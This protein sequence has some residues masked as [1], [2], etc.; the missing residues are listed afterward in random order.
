MAQ[1]CVI[2]FLGAKIFDPVIAIRL[3]EM[4]VSSHVPTPAVIRLKD[5]IDGAE[6]RPQT[7]RAKRQFARCHLSRYSESVPVES[8]FD[9]F[10]GS[11]VDRFAVDGPPFERPISFRNRAGLSHAS[12]QDGAESV[13]RIS[14]PSLQSPTASNINEAIVEKLPCRNRR[15]SKRTQECHV[16][17]PRHHGR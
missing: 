15:N 8:R 16:Q 11:P 4:L 14:E 6:S 10:E 1:I 13:T 7:N 2:D 17:E 12:A 9:E 3:L 5:L